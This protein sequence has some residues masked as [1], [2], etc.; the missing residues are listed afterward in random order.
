[1]SS[2]PEFCTDPL[3][4]EDDSDSDSESD[5]EDIVENLKSFKP[6]NYEIGRAHV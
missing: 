4:N 1:M 3:K 6:D 2:M 5:R